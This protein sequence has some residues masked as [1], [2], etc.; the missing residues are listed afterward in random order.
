[1]DARHRTLGGFRRP[2][3]FAGTGARGPDWYV[4]LD[5]TRYRLIAGTAA[6]GLLLALRPAADGT[7]PFAFG[8]PIRQMTVKQGTSAKDSRAPLTFEFLS[9]PFGGS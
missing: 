2:H 9:V 4:V 8:P 7:G 5:G 3:R 1:M 6:D